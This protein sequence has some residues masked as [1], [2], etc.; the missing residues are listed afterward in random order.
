M[1]C[2]DRDPVVRIGSSPGRL[3]GSFPVA[4]DRVYAFLLAHTEALP[5]LSRAEHLARFKELVSVFQG[6]CRR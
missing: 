4:R 2:S 6:R 5:C 1:A 3:L